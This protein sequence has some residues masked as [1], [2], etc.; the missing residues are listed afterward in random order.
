MQHISGGVIWSQLV[1]DTVGPVHDPV[2]T[3]DPCL[4]VQSLNPVENLDD[5]LLNMKTMTTKT[6]RAI[7]AIIITFI[8]SSTPFF[9]RVMGFTSKLEGNKSAQCHLVMLGMIVWR[10]VSSAHCFD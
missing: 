5:E 10:F 6:T 9:E 4:L 3:H 7:A 2:A 1:F 8:A